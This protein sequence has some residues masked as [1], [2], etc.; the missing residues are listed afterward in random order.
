MGLEEALTG[1]DDSFHTVAIIGTPL[2]GI[3]LM[4]L[5]SMKLDMLPQLGFRFSCE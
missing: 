3:F 5:S 2:C 1:A 4:R